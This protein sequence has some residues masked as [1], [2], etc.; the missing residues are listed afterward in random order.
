MQT[1]ICPCTNAAP[2]AKQ[3]APEPTVHVTNTHRVS[4]APFQTLD[5]ALVSGEKVGRVIYG[6]HA[7]LDAA[8]S[9][10]LVVMVN[11]IELSAQIIA[12]VNEINK[13][14]IEQGCVEILTRLLCV[15]GT[16]DAKQLQHIKAL[17]NQQMTNLLRDDI[18]NA[19]AE[20][21]KSRGFFSEV[22]EK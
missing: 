3:Q 8:A 13:G 10:K 1:P 9:E 15:F 7:L 20:R 22:G 6:A 2:T 11:P 4:I 12:S 18:T 16:T 5:D 21:L 14:N 17:I 19:T